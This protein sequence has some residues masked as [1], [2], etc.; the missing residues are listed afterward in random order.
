MPYDSTMTFIQDSR[1]KRWDSIATIT[2]ISTSG[3]ML[4]L[5]TEEGDVTRR[6][7]RFI[8]PKCAIQSDSSRGL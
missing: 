1:T 7:R 2:G 3:R 8:R 5:L 4:D 6:N